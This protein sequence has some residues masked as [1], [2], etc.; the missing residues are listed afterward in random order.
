MADADDF[1]RRLIE[2]ETAPLT[3]NFQQLLDRGVQVPPPETLGE[4]ELTRKLWEV[5]DALA[6]LQVFLRCTDHLSDRELYTELWTRVLRDDV[7]DV[8][9]DES[10]SSIVDLVSTGS[11]ESIRAWLTYYADER[12]RQQWQRDFPDEPMPPHQDPPYHR[13]GRLP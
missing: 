3:T 10:T 6:D 2:A 1:E 4:E 7:E 12:T 8:P 9:V 13:D 5:I 11:A